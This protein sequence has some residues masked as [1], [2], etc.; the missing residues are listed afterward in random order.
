M[1]L[2]SVTFSL[3]ATVFL[4]V[5]DLHFLIYLGV[6]AIFSAPVFILAA[7]H[8]SKIADDEFS[9]RNH[10]LSSN[11]VVTFSR[12]PI[13]YPIVAIL[14]YVLIPLVL[15]ILAEVFENL[16]LQSAA[17]LIIS[18]VAL[19]FR[20]FSLVEFEVLSWWSVVAVGAYSLVCL[21]SIIA[22]FISKEKEREKMYLEVANEI[23]MSKRYL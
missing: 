1:F 13:Y 23:Q 11:R 19:I 3:L 10:Y 7:H 12:V 22:G 9:A 15:V 6:G 5:Q 18:P 14:P 21:V 8:G 17:L 16:A 20:G 4:F 2:Y